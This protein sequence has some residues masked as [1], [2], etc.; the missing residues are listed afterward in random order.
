MSGVRLSAVCVLPVVLLGLQVGGFG[1]GR[2]TGAKLVE[3]QMPAQWVPFTA[4]KIVRINA[5]ASEQH[6]TFYRR[7]DGSTV[8]TVPP[9]KAISCCV[10]LSAVARI[11][12]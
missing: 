11:F 8:T 3:I 9:L 12:S 10:S 1:Q 6:G 5:D 2:S 4:H 7:A